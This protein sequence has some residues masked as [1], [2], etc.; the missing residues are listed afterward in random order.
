MN[1]QAKYHVAKWVCRGLIAIDP[2]L[3]Y[4]M[5][6][7][8]GSGRDLLGYL[9]LGICAVSSLLYFDLYMFLLE[10]LTK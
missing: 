7:A 6:W 8:F 2:P 10:K 3:L 4:L 9:L 5:G 1:P